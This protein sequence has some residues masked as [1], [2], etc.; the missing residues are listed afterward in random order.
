MFP[1]FLQVFSIYSNCNVYT[2]DKN[3]FFVIHIKQYNMLFEKCLGLHI[4]STLG[5]R[6]K[7]V[8]NALKIT[9]IQRLANRLPTYHFYVG[10]TF[11]SYVGPTY[12]C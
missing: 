8:G 10:P 3:F 2:Y 7:S 1:C 12:M 9:N 6:W 11:E 4:Y 5:Q